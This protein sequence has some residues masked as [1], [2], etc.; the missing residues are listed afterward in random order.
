MPE[1]RYDE[2]YFRETYGCDSLPRFGM[3]WWSVRWYA[4]MARRC[5]DRNGGRRLLE[6]GCGHGFTLAR[7]EQRYETWG[8]DISE[9]AIGRAAEFAPR[10]RCMV[11]DV[12]QGFPAALTPG[13]FDLVMAKYVFEHLR[14]PG[15]ALRRAAGLLRPGGTLFISMPYTASLGARLKGDDWYARKDPTHCSLLSRDT[16]LGLVA[17]A[18]LELEQESADGWW[19]V[20]Y[21]AGIPAWLQLPFVI[22]PTAAACL[23]GRAVLPARWGENVLLFAQRPA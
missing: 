15:L 7:L 11:A 16:W 6:I 14:D 1:Q 2:Q 10:S 8:V 4:S 22:G 21:V 17:A 18:G 20:P 23:A 19:D 9:Y 3:H 13:S 12:D 5:L